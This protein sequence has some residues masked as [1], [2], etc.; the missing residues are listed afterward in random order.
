[1]K[2]LLV[3]P[4][5]GPRTIGMRH[6]ARIEPLGLELVGAGVSG[7][8]DVRL[9]DMFVRPADLLRTLKKFTPDVVGVTTECVRMEPALEVLRQIRKLVPGCLTVIGGHHPTM[10]PEE[11]YDPALDVIV[12]NEGVEAFREICQTRAGGGTRFDHIRG[13]MIRTPDGLVATEPRPLP[14]DLDSQPFPDRRLTARYRKRYFFLT[15]PSAAAMR[16][17]YGCRHNCTFCPGTLYFKRHLVVR[18]PRLMFEEISTIKEPFIQFCDNGTFHDPEKM[19]ALGEML[20]KAGIKKR[21]YAYTRADVITRNPE[22]MELWARAGL[23]IVF[24]GLEACDDESLRRMNKGS[25]VMQNEEALRVLDELG[26]S[27]TAGFV[28]DPAATKEDFRTMRRYINRHR[29]ILHAEFTPLTPFKGTR[30]YEQQKDNV[31][32]HDWQLYD[33]QHFVVKTLL[34]PKVLYRYIFHSYRRIVRRVIFKEQLWRPVKALQWRN[35]KLIYGLVRN[36]IALRRAHRHIPWVPL[37]PSGKPKTPGAAATKETA[38]PDG[39]PQ[40]RDAERAEAEKQLV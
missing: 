39:S 21:Y 14:P 19:Q 26:I 5:C 22:L 13:L 1:M 18:D 27:V 24:I 25:G 34:P 20:I 33:L 30:F 10:Y 32:T 12:L 29:P 37:E 28:I 38:C 9:V 11:F 2:I 36:A 8:H 23:S 7:E 16:T 3:N 40:P 31:V 17:A 4:P 15:E 35:L 6:I